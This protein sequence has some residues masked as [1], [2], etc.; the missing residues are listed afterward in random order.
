M[1]VILYWSILWL[2]S[3]IQRPHRQRWLSSDS[4]SDAVA[5]MVFLI[6]RHSDRL[7]HWRSS[8]DS[9]WRWHSTG[10]SFDWS[11]GFSDHIT[12]GDC[13]RT[14]EVTQ[15]HRWSSWLIGTLIDFIT[16]DCLR[17]VDEVT[18]Y[19]STLWLISRIQRPHRQRWLAS[20]SQQMTFLRWIKF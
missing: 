8:S 10:Q 15:L 13:L 17:T 1:T 14:V 18:F 12:S 16:G 3:R 4:W 2:I 11:V 5:P 9:R 7:H 6:N 20:G 19:R